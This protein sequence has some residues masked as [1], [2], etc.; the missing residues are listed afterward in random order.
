[1]IHVEFMATSSCGERSEWMLSAILQI[2]EDFAEHAH[3]KKTINLCAYASIRTGIFIV[4]MH[5]HEDLL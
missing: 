3:Q 2:R 4:P 1:M 5:I